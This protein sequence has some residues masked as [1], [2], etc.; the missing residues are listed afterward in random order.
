MPRFDNAL[1]H[2]Q[3]RSHD[4]F[5][6]R[7]AAPLRDGRG[8]VSHTTYRVR[9]SGRSADAEKRHSRHDRTDDYPK[10]DSNSLHKGP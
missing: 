9:I 7:S 4:S 5:N 2:G 1:I 6:Y 3:L 8:S 10:S